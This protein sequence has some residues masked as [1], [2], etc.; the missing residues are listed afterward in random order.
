MSRN[1]MT[2]LRH[3][4]TETKSLKAYTSDELYRAIFEHAA[5]GIL[6]LDTSGRYIEAN[7]R[8]CKML[9][10]TREEILKFSVDDLVAPENLQQ[11]PL[12]SE[13]LRAERMMIYERLLRRK[14]GAYM[15]VEV[16]ARMLSDGMILSLLRD[17]SERKQSE[18]TLREAE[19]KHLDFFKYSIDGI[20]QSTPE[21]RFLSVNPALARIWGYESPEEVL[22]SITNIAHQ[23]YVIPEQRDEFLRRMDEDG[24]VEAFEFQAYRKDD[25]VIWVHENVRAVK[26]EYG[27]LKY[28][29]GSIEDITE[30]KQIHEALRRS[31]ERYR[32]TLN[33]M[34]EGCQIIDYDWRYIYVNDTA[35]IQGRHKPEEMLMHSMLELYPGIEKTELFAILQR[36]MEER[37][38]RRM[39]NQFT[40]IEGDT[41]WF[42]LSI[43]PVP[44]GLFI[45]SIDIT[46]RK[47]AESELRDRE[48]RYRT[49]FENIPIPVFTKDRDGR[50]TSFN[51]E[52]AKYWAESPLGHTDN[53][54]LPAEI[55]NELRADDLQVME[56][57]EPWFGEEKFQ[58]SS[59]VHYGLVRK[60]PLYD[61]TGNVIG[62]LGASV[63]I[64]ERKRA[65]KKIKQ[66]LERL[67]ALSEIDRVIASS[68]DLNLTLGQL[69]KHVIRQLEVD[70]ATI[71]L[72][73]PLTNTLELVAG[74][75]FHGVTPKKL[76]VRIS[77]DYAGKVALERHMVQVPN[78]GMAKPPLN[79]PFMTQAEN[80]VAYYGLP[81][82]AKGQ[83]KGVLEVFLRKPIDP[84]EEWLS[85]LETLAEQ[86]AIAIDNTQ[87]FNDLQ[88]SNTELS[89]AYDATIEGWSFA[90]DLRDK[91][92]EGHTQRVTDMTFKLSK[93]FG[94]RDKELNYIRWGALLHDIGKMGVPDAILQ[95]PD[96]LTDEEL[97]IMKMHPIFARNM[98]ERINYL[99]SAIDIPYCHHEKWD[100]SGYPRGL[101]DEEIP[102]SARIFAVVDMW[103]TLT[104][105]RPYRP[106]WS[107]RDALGF[108]KDGAGSYFDPQVVILFLE[109]EDL[110]NDSNA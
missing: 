26:D 89:L 86:A 22:E 8:I 6:I 77:D 72:A 97:E 84:D 61:G 91:E 94:L 30:Q 28:Y 54:L 27:N 33:N 43:E 100:G 68:I 37:T 99:K 79:R 24:K 32:R 95:K 98:L 107:K 34:L 5:D 76:L 104:S 46:E 31:E 105:D 2:S 18:E 66:Q 102:L 7:P 74:E 90:L 44:E 35:A 64:T 67:T 49:L 58:A 55:A 25:G 20:F 70:A 57:E 10:Y 75:G 3:T 93:K 62:I 73:N 82:V 41:G 81:L 11:S 109:S 9:G 12:P 23:V 56:T 65:E 78:L 38:P 108:I 39:E 59:G 48:A 87:L 106:A 19:Q 45:L 47:Q 60:V 83:I 92:T 15:P 52:E 103:D 80:F 71:L 88:Q 51:A 4:H 63:D 50:Y 14:D 40:F 1:S 42:E 29:E 110:W 53:E 36:C 101:K 85:Y 16:S 96:K 69:I 17:T 13:D 21:G